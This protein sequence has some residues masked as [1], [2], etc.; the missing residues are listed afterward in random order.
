MFEV[1]AEFTIGGAHSPA[2]FSVDFYGI[3][4]QIEHGFDAN[5]HTRLK[6][7]AFAPSG[8][9]GNFGRFME[10]DTATMADEIADDAE[11]IASGAFFDSGTDI[12]DEC[13]ATGGG[14]TVSEGLLSTVEQT[15]HFGGR[16]FEAES[17]CGIAHGSVE[18]DT[19]ID[20]DDIVFGKDHI[21]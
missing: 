18:S 3:G 8:I 16:F 1:R 4:S 21:G 7:G 19:D 14:D 5:D 17:Q 15:L 12:A 11:F 10:F 13:T 6:F 2:V 20:A 9:V